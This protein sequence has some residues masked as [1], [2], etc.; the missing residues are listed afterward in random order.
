M[1]PAFPAEAYFSYY[2]RREGLLFNLHLYIAQLDAGRGGL[3]SEKDRE[4]YKHGGGKGDR[5]KIAKYILHP[6]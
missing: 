2:C 1:R 4:S 3:W 6:N 5:G